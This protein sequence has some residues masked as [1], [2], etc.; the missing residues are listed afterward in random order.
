M[1]D[2]ST[3]TYPPFSVLTPLPADRPRVRVALFDFDGTIS[4]LRQGWEGIMTPLMLECIAGSTEPTDELRQEVAEYIDR[5]TGVQTIHQMIWLADAVV[6]HGLN[7][8]VHDP[9]WYKAEYNRRLLEPV[10]ARAEQV[11][12]GETPAEDF[13]IAGS[14]AFLDALRAAGISMYVASGTDH[15]DVMREVGTLGLSDYFVEIAGA[16]VGAMDCSKEAVLRR[17]VQDAGLAGPEVLVIGDG[18]VEI[19]LAREV[20]AIALGVATDEVAR[21]GV[22]PVKYARLSKAGA[23]AI[24]G[25]FTPLAEILG[26][27]GIG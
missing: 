4:A 24:S 25:D 2:S 16:P 10:S 26:W 5:S 15:P 9:W 7:P 14:R 22:N 19:A 18:R 20:G 1:T 11:I 8:I 13:L 12:S 6:R 21:S 23:H 27:L 3:T 17:L